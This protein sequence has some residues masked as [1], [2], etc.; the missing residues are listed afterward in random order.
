M[1]KMRYLVI[2]AG[3]FGLTVCRELM[4]QGHEVVLL[5]KDEN[6]VERLS[7]EVT[8]AIVGDA[9]DQD[10]LVAAGASEMDGA[11]VAIGSELEASILATML[12][13]EIGVPIIFSKAASDNHGRVLARIGADRLVFPE[14]D[15]GI[16][17]AR[18]IQAPSFLELGDL[19]AGLSFAELRVGERGRGKT[20]RELDVQ[21]RLGVTVA[22]MRIAAREVTDDQD[23]RQ[24]PHE[25][26]TASA[27]Q[28]LKKGD[29]LLAVGN[30]G[31][32]EELQ[33]LVG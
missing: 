2:G 23:V 16:R 33:K 3:S 25:V 22:A 7:D 9:S 6:L 10:A 12:L 8:R 13:K 27:S 28:V 5:D 32:L 31:K 4:R 1:A 18:L 14:R 11:I 15:A 29:V 21:R 20:L 26:C 30:R 17:V 19:T 24:L